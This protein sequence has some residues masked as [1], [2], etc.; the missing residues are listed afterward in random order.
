LK[1]L[2]KNTFLKKISG[3]GFGKLIPSIPIQGRVLSIIIPPDKLISFNKEYNQI[4][5]KIK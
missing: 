1:F 5:K 3:R 2:K 4:I